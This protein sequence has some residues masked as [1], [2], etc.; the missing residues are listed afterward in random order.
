MHNI[1]HM[2]ICHQKGHAHCV[3]VTLCHRDAV[4]SNPILNSKKKIPTTRTEAEGSASCGR[5]IC[6]SEAIARRDNHAV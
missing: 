5:Q 2:Y 6:L 3:T 1:C 4:T